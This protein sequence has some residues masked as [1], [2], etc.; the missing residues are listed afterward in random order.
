MTVPPILCTECLGTNVQHCDWVYP[1]TG[2]IVGDL[3][4]SWEDLAS[5]GKSWCDDCQEHT[6]LTM[7]TTTMTS[8]NSTKDQELEQRVSQLEDE[9]ETLLRALANADER[10]MRRSRHPRP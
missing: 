8:Q 9:V 5:Q 3:G 7:T 1:N 10:E 2:E 6:V 4:S